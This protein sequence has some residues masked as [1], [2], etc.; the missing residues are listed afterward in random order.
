MGS[1]A[2]VGSLRADAGDTAVVPGQ[3]CAKLAEHGLKRY[4]ETGR[5]EM[6]E[7]A[8]RFMAEH[9]GGGCCGA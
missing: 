9:R 7:I 6:T 4:A 2:T 3:N 5:L 1:E 8:T